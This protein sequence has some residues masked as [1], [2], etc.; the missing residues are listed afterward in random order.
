MRQ[1]ML[2]S[3][4]A[5]VGV[6]K[7]AS[8]FGVDAG[9]L[10]ADVGLDQRT[11]RDPRLLVDWDLAAVFIERLAARARCPHLGLLVLAQQPPLNIG[12][13]GHLARSARDLGTAM[14]LIARY[15]TIWNQALAWQIHFD[16]DD[17]HV[18]RL[19][20]SRRAA[21]LRQVCIMGVGAGVTA[22]KSIAGGGWAPLAVSFAF[23][24]PRNGAPFRE[25]FGLP[26]YFGQEY[27]GFIVRRRDL[28]MPLPNRDDA[29]FRVLDAHAKSLLGK[30]D[31]EDLVE[32]TRLLLR[33]HLGSQACTLRGVAGMLGLHPK[34]FQRRLQERGHTFREIAYAVRYEVVREH[35]ERGQAPLSELAVL[36]GLSDASAVSRGF[37]L[38]HGLSPERWRRRSR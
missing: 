19:E 34:A 7:V 10:A 36:V 1:P 14:R 9:A 28:A 8:R 15:I 30:S 20:R 32:Q 12:L 23:D 24:R 25:F 21:G 16:G 26:V 11:L 17:V 37:K 38:R 22:L 31:S 27:S 4:E 33:R 35:L 29:L 2:I 3:G 18:A 13:L 5:L 6:A